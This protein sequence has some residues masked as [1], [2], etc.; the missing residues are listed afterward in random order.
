MTIRR[1]LLL[2]NLAILTLLGPERVVSITGATAN[3]GSGV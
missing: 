2:S 3:T 1:R